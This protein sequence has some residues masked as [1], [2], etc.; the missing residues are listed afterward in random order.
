MHILICNINTQTEKQVFLPLH[1]PPHLQRQPW[2]PVSH[3]SLWKLLCTP[4]GSASDLSDPK[5]LTV[6]VMPA[7]HSEFMSEKRKKKRIHARDQGGCSSAAR[8]SHRKGNR[9]SLKGS[10]KWGFEPQLC[11][12]DAWLQQTSPT[13]SPSFVSGVM[14]PTSQGSSA[15][16]QSRT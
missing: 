5:H 13:C 16:G 9:A 2:V 1:S 3:V 7:G 12:I 11:S 14:I 4:H 6:Q 15:E 8:S 10:A